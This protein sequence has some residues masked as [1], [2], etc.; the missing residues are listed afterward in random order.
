MN[1][2][3]EVISEL[4]AHLNCPNKLR[5]YKDCDGRENMDIEEDKRLTEWLQ[6]QKQKEVTL[7]PTEVI[8][9]SFFFN[10]NSRAGSDLLIKHSPETSKM[11]DS[12]IQKSSKAGST[13]KKVNKKNQQDEEADYLAFGGAGLQSDNIS[14]MGKQRRHNL[15]T[16]GIPNMKGYNYYSEIISDSEEEERR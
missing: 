11:Y 6:G 14:V 3:A 16:T 7:R 12:S 9:R 4:E 2:K 10:T 8:T 5:N 1:D 15:D 13:A